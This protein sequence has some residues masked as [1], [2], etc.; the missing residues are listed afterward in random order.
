VSIDVPRTLVITNDFPPRV[1][2]VQRVVHS[3]VRE[4]P[5]DRVTVLAPNWP[6]WREHDDAEPYRIERFP[7][8]FLWPTRDLG[9]RAWSLARDMR[10]DVVLFGHVVPTALL[11]RGL[12]RRGVPS[13][14]LAHGA[15][16]WEALVPGT[17]TLLR[18]ATAATQRVAACS[19]FVGRTVRTVVPR[20]VPVSV[21]TPGADVERFR[22]DLDASE[23]RSRHRLSDR[24]VISCVSRL[25]PR[26]GQDVLILAME[27]IRRRVPD[28]ALLIV[29][30]GSYRKTLE[31][32]AAAKAPPNSV[33]FA[34][35]VPEDELP[36]HYAA[37]DVFAMPCRNR[38]L[39]LEVEGWGAV[40]QEAAACGEAVVAGDS[41]G[42]AEAVADGETGLVVDGRHVGQ[43]AEA[44]AGLLDDPQRAVRMGK[45]GRARVEREYAWPVIAERLAGWLREAAESSPRM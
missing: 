15:E 16:Y 1:G 38:Y 41:G 24:P 12:S 5:P 19:A 14:A 17:A 45:A 35:E 28:A 7:P 13:V 44:V 29:G 18:R 21:L 42:A 11:S 8:T 31:T 20:Q 43:V 40:F 4:L 36:L 33:Y 39:G 37:G 26:K 23:I 3:L 10:A 32:V 25:V 34:G 2:G 9:R 30:D 22:P 27:A 6:G